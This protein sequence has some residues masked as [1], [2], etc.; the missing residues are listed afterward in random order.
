MNGYIVK[1][2]LNCKPIAFLKK[3]THKNPKN[4]FYDCTLSQK[5]PNLEKPVIVSLS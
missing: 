1:D 5:D 3:H 2:S 4:L